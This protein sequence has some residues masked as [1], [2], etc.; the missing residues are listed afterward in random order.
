MVQRKF[1]L[2]MMEVKT[3]IA[4]LRKLP[5]QDSNLETQLLFGEE[6]EIIS[7]EKKDWLLCKSIKDNYEGWIKKNNI[8][9]YLHK[10]NYKVSALTTFI[11]KEPN[12]KSNMSTY[13]HLNSKL[14]IL[15]SENDWSIFYYNQNK[16][17]IFNKHISKIISKSK[18]ENNWVETAKK[19]LNTVYL[20]GGKSALGLDC[21][22][23]V[24]L[25]L[26]HHNIPFP[27]NTED[28]F[29]SSFLKSINENEINNGTLIF[30]KGHVA[31]AVNKYEI[32]HANAY[33][34]QVVI[35]SLREAKKRIEPLYGKIIGYKKLIKEN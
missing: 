19:F 17:F 28:Q 10:K 1:N 4:N 9:K 35:E 26:E 25:C 7:E 5:D 21:S 12:I 2:K 32:I 16:A 24:Q 8:G 15:K 23:L 31:I 33:H 27:R 3:P 13:L 30:W 18:R 22:G 14:H 11:F 20:W 29:N 6:V 34:M